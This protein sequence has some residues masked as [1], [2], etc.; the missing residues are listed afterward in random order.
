MLLSEGLPI[1]GR[2]VDGGEEQ[3]LLGRLGAGGVLLGFSS[4]HG[5]LQGV[6][7]L[8]AEEVLPVLLR[9]ALGIVAEKAG[10]S[11]ARFC[12]RDDRAS[13]P[14]AVLAALL[15]FRKPVQ[16]RISAR[17]FVHE[18]GSSER[19]K[20]EAKPTRRHDSARAAGVAGRE[21]YCT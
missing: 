18:G 2:S 5:E 9:G 6:S 21:I 11:V 17:G 3:M 10:R 4:L 8:Q 20:A 13:V 12:C 19:G 1:P 7:C 14:L 15:R 16:D